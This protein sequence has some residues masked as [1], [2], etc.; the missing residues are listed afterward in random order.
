MAQKQVE[1]REGMDG[2]SDSDDRYQLSQQ[3][4][5]LQ[6]RMDTTVIER[7]ELNETLEYYISINEHD[8]IISDLEQKYQEQLNERLQK[9][10]S[11][12]EH[13][14]ILEEKMKE[15][16]PKS[17][18]AKLQANFDRLEKEVEKMRESMKK[19]GESFQNEELHETGENILRDALRDSGI[20]P[21]AQGSDTILNEPG[22]YPLEEA[23]Q[24]FD[25]VPDAQG[26]NQNLEGEISM[27]Q[28]EIPPDTNSESNSDFDEDMPM[29]QYETTSKRD[30]KRKLSTNYSK[31]PDTK[32]I[33]EKIDKMVV[34]L[35]GSFMKKDKEMVC[36]WSAKLYSKHMN[37]PIDHEQVKAVG[38]GLKNYYIKKAKE[39]QRNKRKNYDKKKA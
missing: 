13:E 25:V 2:G 15:Y 37:L 28:K 27:K 26:S 30:G 18:F 29:S 12:D 36:D 7:E 34:K 10:I 31:D 3:V 22:E 24:V 39:W 1:N 19:K 4:T 20:V 6:V 21:D 23:L 17:D 33:C 8:Q 35:N 38:E 9:F 14:Q 5:N 16:V 11:I 32:T